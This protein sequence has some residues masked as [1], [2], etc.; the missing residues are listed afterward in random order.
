M[1]VTG[2]G[3]AFRQMSLAS[4]RE[5]LRNSKTLVGLA[6][7]FVFFLGLVSA[8]H[9]VDGLGHPE[10]V[11]TVASDGDVRGLVAA[12]GD[13]GVEVVAHGDTAANATITVAGSAAIV[14]FASGEAP[15]W[16]AVVRAVERAGMPPAEITVIDEYGAPQYDIL[17]ANLGTVV[18]SG[19]VAIVFAGT[20]VPLVA[21]RGRGTLRLL[22]TTPVSRL[23]FVIAQTPVRILL[24]SVEIVVVLALAVANGYIAPN[25][26]WRLPVTLLI[27]FAML[28]AF[29]F[30]LAS[31]S[32]NPDLM[33]QVVGGIP[34]IVLFGSG[35][36]VPLDV[37]PP[38]V[39]WIS[40]ALPSTWF[41]QAINA[42]VGGV[43]STLP[44]GAL[45][46][47]MTAVTLVVLAISVRVFRW[48]RSGV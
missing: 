11:V 37:L 30:L 35:T 36:L 12:L 9:I 15:R 25:G 23:Q 29:A 43:P 18:V 19:L 16:G 47:L 4:S 21:M 46:A 14:T 5:L 38:F 1:S 26:L 33:L 42:D 28:F 34:V 39:S 32:S 31:R 2:R 3:A 10:P 20:T 22:G 27:G 41:M 45:W 6:A 44:I 40:S 24:G 7:I 17:R 8:L 13:A 48:G